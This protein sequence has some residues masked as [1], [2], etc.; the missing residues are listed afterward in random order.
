MFEDA[1]SFCSACQYRQQQRRSFSTM[2]RVK[3]YLR[4][5]MGTEHMSGLVLLNIHREREMDLEEIIDIFA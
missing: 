3:T 1:S 2:R 5:T 4:C